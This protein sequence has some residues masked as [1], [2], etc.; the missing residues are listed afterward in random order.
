VPLLQIHQ[1]AVTTTAMDDFIPTNEAIIRLGV[2]LGVFTLMAI[3]EIPAPRRPLTQSKPLRWL[4]NIT[5]VLVN[6]IVVRMVL[7]TAAVA[8]IAFSSH[9]LLR[10]RRD[11]T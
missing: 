9:V 2:F 7:P 5:L 1:Q 6:T 4:N 8:A 10:M 11:R 3:W